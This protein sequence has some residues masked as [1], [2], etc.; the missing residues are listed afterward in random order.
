[1][2]GDSTT[3]R[4]ISGLQATSSWTRAAK[5]LM[6]KQVKMR[7]PAQQRFG[8]FVTPDLSGGA[9]FATASAS[10]RL[11]MFVR[12]C[13]PVAKIEAGV[14][15]GMSSLGM[16][17]MFSGACLPAPASRHELMFALGI[18]AQSFTGVV[19]PNTHTRMRVVLLCSCLVGKRQQVSP[20]T[21]VAAGAEHAFEDALN[22]FCDM[23]RPPVK[24]QC[25][26]Y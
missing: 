15:F 25:C 18:P 9:T 22:A 12:L 14:R 16:A 7:V 10:V 20:W 8:Y 17:R 26:V 1:V 11:C 21:V 19:G 5:L 24:R 23:R 2:A 3:C 13:S 6:A 4:L